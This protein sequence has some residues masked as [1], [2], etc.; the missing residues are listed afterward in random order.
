MNIM[1]QIEIDWMLLA[2]SPQGKFKRVLSIS[3]STVEAK[4]YFLVVSHYRSIR[5][6]R[7]SGS[8]SIIVKTSRMDDR[9]IGVYPIWIG[10]AQ[11]SVTMI[12]W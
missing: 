2:I 9:G 10:Y 5:V 11:Y 12:I 6:K 7:T 4:V 1:P 3:L 8:L